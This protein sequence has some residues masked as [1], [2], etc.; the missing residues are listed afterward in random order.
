VNKD[1]GRQS[2]RELGTGR[3]V[4]IK[5]LLSNEYEAKIGWVEIDEDGD[6]HALQL[7]VW[8]AEKLAVVLAAVMQASKNKPQVDE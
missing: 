4:I 5:A 8:Q 1:L 7:E 6:W 2:N 3:E